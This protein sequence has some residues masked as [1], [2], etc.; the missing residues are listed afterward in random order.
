MNDLKIESN[1]Q[2]CRSL[3]QRF[4]IP[5]PALRYY[6]GKWLLAPWIIGYFPSHDCYVEPFAGAASVL[7]QKPPS[8]IEVYNDL[9]GDVVN[10]FKMLRERPQDLIEAINLTPYS[11]QEYRDA[12]QPAEDSLESARRFY[13]WSWQ[14]RGRGGV[15]EPGGWRFMSRKTRGKTPCGDFDNTAHLWEVAK[16]LKNVH[17]ENDDALKVIKRYDTEKT[18]FYVDPPYVQSTRG[19]RWGKSGYVFECSDDQHQKIAEILHSVKGMVVL[20]GYDSPLYDYLY[21]NWH[22]AEKATQKDSGMKVTECLWISPNCK[23]TL[24]LFQKLAL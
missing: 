5:R 11:R 20:S 14:G 9:N 3:H 17:I 4:V 7:L 8:F 21:S 19:A 12:Q 24:P 15:K 13:T 22:K 16:R 2:D 18:L 1:T 6:G 23:Q 10:F